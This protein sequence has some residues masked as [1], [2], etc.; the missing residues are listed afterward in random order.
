MY[1]MEKCCSY[2]NTH[3]PWDIKH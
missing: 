2:N 3:R 1:L